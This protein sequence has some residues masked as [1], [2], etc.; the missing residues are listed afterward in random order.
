M[1][2]SYYHG[3][4]DATI[5]VTKQTWKLLILLINVAFFYV[6]YNFANN[7]EII[8]SPSK[9]HFSFNDYFVNI[10]FKHLNYLHFFTFLMI[11]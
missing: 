3:K 4:F 7:N 6:H 10:G 11:T 5:Y 2:K 9:K 1:L 8:T